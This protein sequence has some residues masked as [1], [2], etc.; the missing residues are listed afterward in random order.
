MG[1]SSST[2][3]SLW[4]I[5]SYLFGSTDRADR[6]G[7]QNSCASQAGP[8]R[9]GQH[10]AAFHSGSWSVNRDLVGSSE[11][12]ERRSVRVSERAFRAWAQR[13]VA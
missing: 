7:N 12:P 1:A 3:R 9:R 10:E 2:G 13:T 4:W 6:T 8:E 5:S 11:G